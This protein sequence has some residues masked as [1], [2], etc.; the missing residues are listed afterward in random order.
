MVVRCLMFF[1]PFIYLF[2]LSPLYLLALIYLP[3]SCLNEFFLIPPIL[4]Y[5]HYHVPTLTWGWPH[6]SCQKCFPDCDS[7]TSQHH[8]ELG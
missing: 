8:R 7:Y 1:L 5:L 3:T 6:G 4:G 2:F